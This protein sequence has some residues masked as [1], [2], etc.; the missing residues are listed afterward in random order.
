MTTIVLASADGQAVALANSSH[1][2]AR[3]FVDQFDG[4]H[5]EQIKA[6]Q[7]AAFRSNDQRC[8]VC[9]GLLA[10]SCDLRSSIVRIDPV[11]VRFAVATIMRNPAAARHSGESAVFPFRSGFDQRNICHTRGWRALELVADGADAA[12]PG[13]APPSISAHHQPAIGLNDRSISA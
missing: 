9:A 8:E 1:L 10:S 11:A 6:H 7:L 3:A 12:W 4:T 5:V 2:A 13:R